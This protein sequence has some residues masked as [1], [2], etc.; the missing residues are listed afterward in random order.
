MRTAIKVNL[1]IFIKYFL[2]YSLKLCKILIS[3]VFVEQMLSLNESTS[4]SL[5]EKNGSRQWGT[6]WSDWSCDLCT[7][8][9]N[10]TSVKCIQCLTPRNHLN[11]TELESEITASNEVSKN[12][13]CPESQALDSEKSNPMDSYLNDRNRS[14]SLGVLAGFKWSC[15]ACTYDN[16]NASKKCVL[17]ATPRKTTPTNERQESI[18][19]G[20]DNIESNEEKRKESTSPLMASN[21]S[22][23]CESRSHIVDRDYNNFK[24]K[25]NE[26]L[27]E[28]TPTANDNYID[29]NSQ[30]IDDIYDLDLLIGQSSRPV[31]AKRVPS[32]VNRYLAA[33]IRRLFAS[34]LKQ[35]KGEFGCYFI[36]ELVTFALPPEIEDLSPEIQERLFDEY[37]DR[38]VQKGMPQIK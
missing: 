17:C 18:I 25:I 28:V 21:T 1:Q 6:K 36:T 3:I 30:S 10:N 34:S 24:N 22:K 7:F 12:K 38:D 37:L 14:E 13:S 32:D 29:R 11:K 9:N 23:G 35:R 2:L 4:D 5:V 8:L 27:S 26:N 31:R 19:K 20:E 33:D 16:W 15:S